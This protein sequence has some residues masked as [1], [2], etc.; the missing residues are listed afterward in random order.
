MLIQFFLLIY[1]SMD[2]ATGK[3]LT[4]IDKSSM[5]IGNTSCHSR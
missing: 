5:L 4:M 1:D 3:A 2:L